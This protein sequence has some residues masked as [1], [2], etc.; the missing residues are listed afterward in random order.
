M[1]MGGQSHDL[2]A[3]PQEETRY[4]LYNRSCGPQG[5]VCWNGAE[6]LA[7]HWESIPGP[8]SPQPVAVPAE[9]SRPYSAYKAIY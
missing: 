7:L 1:G 5:Q 9:L 6:N 4:P 8:S 3:L 2:T